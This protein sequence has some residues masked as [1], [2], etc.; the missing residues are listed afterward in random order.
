MSC[1]TCQGET[2]T[3]RDTGYQERFCSEDCATADTRSY[4]VQATVRGVLAPPYA[5]YLPV[6]WTVEAAVLS[7]A[8]ARAKIAMS[9]AGMTFGALDVEAVD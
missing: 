1:Q 5:S 8:V 2:R 6:A 9:E 7:E 4:R 3:D